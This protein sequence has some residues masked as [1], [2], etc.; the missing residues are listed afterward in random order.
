MQSPIALL[1]FSVN[2]CVTLQGVPLHCSFV[3]IHTYVK[4]E[5]LPLS[6]SALGIFIFLCL[7]F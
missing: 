5:S 1:N 4:L 7:N 6:C 3:L 2:A